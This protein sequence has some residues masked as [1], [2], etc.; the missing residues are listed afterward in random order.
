MDSTSQ[1]TA[2]AQQPAKKRRRS[3]LYSKQDFKLLMRLTQL[4]ADGKANAGAAGATF[5]VNALVAAAAAAASDAAGA[6]AAAPESLTKT[7]DNGDYGS[8]TDA[9]DCKVEK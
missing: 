4:A 9:G 8:I 6:G 3:P 5:N 1:K 2:A 7:H